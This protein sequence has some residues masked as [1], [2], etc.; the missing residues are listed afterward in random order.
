MS[1]QHLTRQ[2][3]AQRILDN[4]GVHPLHPSQGIWLVDSESEATSYRVDL[5]AHTCECIDSQKGNRC[6]HQLAAEKAAAILAR[7]APQPKPKLTLDQFIA[8]V[9]APVGGVS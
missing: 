6:K 5:N 7:P 1:A 8:Q 4:G 2:D 3:R 9:T